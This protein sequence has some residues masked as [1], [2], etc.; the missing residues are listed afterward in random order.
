[1]SATGKKIEDVTIKGGSGGLLIRLRDDTPGS[2]GDLLLD[3]DERLAAAAGFFRRGRASVELGERMLEAGDLERMQAVLARYEVALE[4]IIS[5]ANVTR[6]LAKQAGIPFK[7]P[8]VQNTRPAP[9][10]LDGEKPEAG[11]GRS[12]STPFDSAE[13]L[14]IRRTLRSGQ[15]VQH[16]ADVIVLG[17]VNPGA[18][19]IA[20]GN[21]IVWGIVR[22]RIQAGA[23][24]AGAVIC[25][26]S[27]RPTQLRI[28]E[29]VAVGSP[30]ALDE[31]ELGP[32]MA[33]VQDGTI[34][35]ESWQPRRKR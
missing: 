1:M 20:G 27:L 28:G 24:T 15:V 18:E 7:L 21:V 33:T 14:F 2:F 16:H 13:A 9:P 31:P 23:V 32:E 10:R 12:S 3:L 19:I 25:A 4:T 26:L 29:V 8:S 22:G 11:R 5:G 30:E 17:D 34:M 35:V 6:S